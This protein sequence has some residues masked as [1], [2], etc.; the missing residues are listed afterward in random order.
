MLNEAR[1][2][3]FRGVIR[4]KAASLLARLRGSSNN[5]LKVI[6]DRHDSYIF[7]VIL[8]N[9]EFSFNSCNPFLFLFH[10]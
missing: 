2:E 4:K 1:V 6:A 5:I 10:L 8:P 3:G 7:L 9:S